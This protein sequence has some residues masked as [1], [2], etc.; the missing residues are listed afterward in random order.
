MKPHNRNISNL[1][2]S[3]SSSTFKKSHLFYEPETKINTIFLLESGL[4]RQYTINP[5]GQEATIH[6][7]RPGAY[8]PILISISGIKNRFYFESLEKSTCLQLPVES[9]LDFL[10][11]NS[12]EAFSLLV[13][14]TQALDGLSKRIELT[15]FNNAQT[16]VASLIAYLAQTFGQPVGTGYRLDTQV[17]HDYLTSWLGLT[18]ETISRQISTLKKSG[19]ITTKKGSIL[20]KDLQ[21]LENTYL[22]R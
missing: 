9:V 1:F 16:K 13:R 18:R 10:H 6:L 3:S 14:S 22:Q 7:F 21:S 11:S 5:N 2:S 20:I 8:F 12:K 17:S 4:V 19:L 15:L